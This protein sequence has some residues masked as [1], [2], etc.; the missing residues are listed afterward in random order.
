MFKSFTDEHRKDRAGK[1]AGDTPGY[2]KN[3]PEA[4]GSLQSPPRSALTRR[5][6]GRTARCSALTAAPGTDGLSPGPAP[7]CPRPHR[8]Q[9]AC[10]PPPGRS[11]PRAGGG[12][13][14]PGPLPA[15]GPPAHRDDVD[16]GGLAGVLQPHQ[17]EL[18]LLLPE[19]RAEPIQQPGEQRQHGCGGAAATAGHSLEDRGRLRRLSAPRAPSQPGSPPHRG[20]MTPRPGS[21]GAPG[22]AAPHSAPCRPPRAQ[23]PG[24]TGGGRAGRGGAIRGG[25]GGVAPGTATPLWRPRW[26][27]RGGASAALRLRER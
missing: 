13:R 16:E 10:R 17:G 23:R 5:S 8:V 22:E 6:A 9:A 25:G 2:A 4:E 24:R 18:H 14:R 15:P 1:A 19:E 3:S 26:L 21:R 11:A 7:G 27:L 20:H 12:T